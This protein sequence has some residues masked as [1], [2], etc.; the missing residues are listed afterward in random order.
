MVM[1]EEPY[2]VSPMVPFNF[3]YNYRVGAYMEKYLQGLSEQ[4]ILG[5]RC[6]EC[7]RV[8]VPPRSACG[9]CST[10][11]E[12]WVEVQPLGTLENFTIGYVSIE[13]GVITDL[14][15]PVVI[16]LVRLEGADSLLTAR[17]MGV[18]PDEVRTG[19]RVQA[20]WKDEPKGTVHD[21]EHF[22]PAT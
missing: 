10:R 6:P 7:K 22:V 16:G 14:T 11:P 5:V 21:L 18:K 9:Q 20:V 3:T 2:N 12:E 15:E 17:I 1:P 19:L 13:K 8:L 4:K